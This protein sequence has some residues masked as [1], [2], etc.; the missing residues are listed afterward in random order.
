MN[1]RMK[2]SLIA[3]LT[4]CLVF[5]L[6]LVAAAAPAKITF[7]L[8]S[9]AGK[10]GEEVAV[11]LTVDIPN[12]GFYYYYEPYVDWELPTADQRFGNWVNGTSINLFLTIADNA[13]S[14]SY[15]VYIDREYTAVTRGPT[16]ITINQPVTDYADVAGTVTVHKQAA[17]GIASGTAGSLVS[18]P[19]TTNSMEPI[20][21]YDLTIPYDP[22]ALEVSV[23]TATYGGSFDYQDESGL[24]KVTWDGQ[25]DNASIAN[26]ELFNVAFKLKT[27][28]P[29]G[30]KPLAI[31]AGAVFK[32]PAGNAMSPFFTRAGSVEVTPN[33]APIAG[34]VGV[35][36]TEIVGQTLTGTYAYSD[37]EEDAEG[38]STFKW[39]RADNA[40]GAN[41]QLIPEESATAYTLRPA[42]K[43][44]YIRFEVTPAANSG[45]SPGIPVK[46]GFTGQIAALTYPVAYD[47]NGATLGSLPT[48]SQSYEEGEVIEA[49]G[50]TGG[51]EKPHHGFAGWT[52]DPLNAGTLYS[53]GDHLT[54]GTE[55]IT[56]YAKWVV[57][58]YTVSFHSN[59]GSAVTEVQADY[60]TAIAAPPRPS[61]S[62]YSFAGWYK[63]EQLTQAWSFD[64]DKIVGDTELYARWSRNSESSG[65]GA[66]TAPA[67]DEGNSV[68]VRVNGEEGIAGT[69]KTTTDKGR[70]T[71][72]VSLDRTKLAALLQS[73][74][75]GAKLSIPV[76]GAANSAAVELSGNSLQELGSK[77]AILEFRTEKGT[78]VLPASQIR[79]QEIARQLGASADLE[80]IRLR[81]EIAD[82][83]SELA[84]A[85]QGAAS[86]DGFTIVAQ[87]LEFRVSAASGSRSAEISIFGN[88]VDREIALPGGTDA[89]RV[90]TGVVV[91]PDGTMRHVPT[92]IV[93][94]NGRQAALIRSLTNSS[95][96]VIWNPVEFKDVANH[97][98]KDAVNDM[99]SRLVIGGAGEG[100]FNPDRDITRAEFAAIV[101]RALGLKPAQGTSSYADVDSEAW[102]YTAVETAR[103]YKLVSGYANG[104]FR[105]AERITREQAL[106]ILAQATRL[107]GLQE[108]LQTAAL[109]ALDGFSDA[110]Q[111][112]AWAK[113]SV[114]EGLR[115]ELVTGRKDNRLAPKSYISRAE[116]AVLVQRLLKKSDLI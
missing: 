39:Y 107:T 30:I 6:D 5:S 31:A 9:V 7:N 108:K 27:D 83:S 50:N 63:D 45:T 1:K 33:L 46:S 37:H 3:V 18:V 73:A 76:A 90:T 95:Y 98:A 77:Q 34:D 91:D 80:Q 10:P 41:E 75:P 49:L 17:V 66:P 15:S 109:P 85:F 70:T 21:Y 88:F 48:N 58:Q 82:S 101:V 81:I 116:V 4:F 13:P 53:P 78:Y 29:L 24:L 104:E 35:T 59:G 32:D 62:G 93:E 71:S 55:S 92:K 25:A 105:P 51:L 67:A 26:G 16:D 8:S 87:P 14:G 11:A 102:Y 54:I 112:S 111:I 60:D 20:G 89:N 43:G 99:G 68:N 38:A 28:S 103:T 65:G 79:L 74:G 36:G 12:D 115:A 2:T 56:L 84:N 113:A 86:K 69:L 61:R 52:L 97:W 94:E 44:K 114:A 96:A 47:G 72:L 19:V 57:N 23:V 42:D 40:G 22:S 100:R 110:D 106:V 64:A